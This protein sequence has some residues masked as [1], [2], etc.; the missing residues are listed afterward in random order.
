MSRTSQVKVASGPVVP[1]D[2]LP[3][4]LPKEWEGESVL[5]KKTS[6]K[7]LSCG[8]TASCRVAEEAW[9]PRPFAPENHSETCRQRTEPAM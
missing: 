8:G 3:P 7:M 5:G 4:R 9:L 2:E 6:N 1:E